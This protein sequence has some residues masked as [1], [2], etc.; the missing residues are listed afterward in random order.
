MSFLFLFTHSIDVN[1]FSRNY[2]L[3]L[4]LSL[5]VIISF[6]VANISDI[7]DSICI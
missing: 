6:L 7:H 3:L 2:D 5:I 4:E 1:E